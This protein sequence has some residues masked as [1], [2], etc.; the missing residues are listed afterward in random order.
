MMSQQPDCLFCKIVAGSIPADIVFRNDL[1]VAF[2]DITPKAPT[3]ILIVPTSHASNAVELA[4]SSPESLTAM[5][6]AAGELAT[7]EGLD[8]YRTAFNTGESGGQTVFHAHMHLLGGRAF[9]WP[10][11]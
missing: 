9:T 6:L 1:V 10:P 2:R 11:G 7:S 5:F 4:G 8:G 3:H